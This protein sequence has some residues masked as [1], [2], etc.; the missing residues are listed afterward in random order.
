M[1]ED[2]D[3][4]ELSGESSACAHPAIHSFTSFALYHPPTHYH[5]S[6]ASTYPL[7][8]MRTD[9]SDSPSSKASFSRLNTPSQEDL[10][11]IPQHAHQ[12]HQ[13]QHQQ[14]ETPI[15]LAAKA[16]RILGLEPGTLP[17][18]RA[19]LENARDEVRRTADTSAP[20]GNYVPYTT[21]STSEYGGGLKGK[22]DRAKKAM[23]IMNGI[24]GVVVGYNSGKEEEM[25]RERRRRAVDGVLYWQKQVARLEAL[26]TPTLSRPNRR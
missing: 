3:Y 11:P 1:F 13:H 2:E 24:P 4:S 25:K 8:C 19:A 15:A 5:V 7:H 22:I 18:A 16:V 21:N 14:T 12:Q 9:R 17:H 6:Q 10:Q 20:F 23:S 26:E